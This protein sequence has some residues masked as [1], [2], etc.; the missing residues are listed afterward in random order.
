MQK[1]LLKKKKKAILDKW[2]SLIVKTYPADGTQFIA[3]NKNHFANPVGSTISKEI[4]NLLDALIE[5]ADAAQFEKA[6]MGINRIRAVQDFTASQAVAFI[7]FLKTAIREE[8][9]E[10]LSDKKAFEEL[11]S[12]ESTIDAIAL[13][14]FDTYMQCREKLHEIKYAGIKRRAAVPLGKKDEK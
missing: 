1:T 3:T 5:G 12:L 14:A 10:S 6:C 11:L 13:I 8:L 4:E 2:F 9:S 7:F